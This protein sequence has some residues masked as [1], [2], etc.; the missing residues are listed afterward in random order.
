MTELKTLNDFMEEGGVLTNPPRIKLSKKNLKQEAIKH[1]NKF[2]KETYSCEGCYLD[3]C[4]E[5]GQSGCS[6]E[7]WIKMFF[8]ITKEDLQ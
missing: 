8:N 5:R 6:A 4:S 3:D 2:P 1:L 7:I